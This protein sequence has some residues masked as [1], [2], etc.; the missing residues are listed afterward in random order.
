M[1]TYLPKYTKFFKGFLLFAQS[2]LI[3][4]S[5]GIFS[6]VIEA[7][8]A[9]QRDLDKAYDLYRFF[10]R[11]FEIF[12]D[13]GK[14]LI[15]ASILLLLSPILLPILIVGYLRRLV[16]A[17]F[18]ELDV[19]FDIKNNT[20]DTAKLKKGKVSIPIKVYENDSYILSI[21]VEEVNLDRLL[22]IESNFSDSDLEPKIFSYDFK[23]P[24]ENHIVYSLETEIVHSSGVTIKGDLVK[25]DL[26]ESPTFDHSWILSCTDSAK[27]VVII[28]FFMVASGNSNESSSDIDEYKVK[29]GGI[30]K[31]IHVVKFGPLN[32]R[33]IKYVQFLLALIAVIS[34][35]VN[36]P[37]LAQEIPKLIQVLSN[38]D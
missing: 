17:K 10:N 5:F 16:Q 31:Y 38:F 6:S 34:S 23:D 9:S 22:D 35:F 1:R 14:L 3:T 30:E 19:H 20:T 37:L 7:N 21:N 18:F 11:I 8:A 27:Q 12:T 24:G 4:I 13:L 33:Q 28:N 15:L 25:K 26:I 29:L 2:F 32:K 36:I